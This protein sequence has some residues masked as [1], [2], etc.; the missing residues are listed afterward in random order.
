MLRKTTALV[1]D[2][3]WEVGQTYLIA[4]ELMV[5]QMW[6]DFFSKVPPQPL[7]SSLAQMEQ[8]ATGGGDIGTVSSLLTFAPK[9]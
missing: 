9:K 5:D 8:I 4:G 3:L 1:T 2:S 7:F 6:S